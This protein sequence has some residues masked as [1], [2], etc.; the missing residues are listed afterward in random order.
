M[1]EELQIAYFLWGILA[2]FTI[3][4]FNR[5]AKFCLLDTLAK[6]MKK[7]RI[8]KFTT[9]TEN[10]KTYYQLEKRVG[11]LQWEDEYSAES[12]ADVQIYRDSLKIEK[13]V[14]E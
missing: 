11:F 12:L 13:K 6:G 3:I 9:G 2:G 10:Q 8:V 4:F 14:I 5:L 1:N 7:Y